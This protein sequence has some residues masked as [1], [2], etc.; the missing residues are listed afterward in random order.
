MHPGNHKLLQL[1]LKQ[2]QDATSADAAADMDTTTSDSQDTSSFQ[3]VGEFVTLSAFTNAKLAHLQ[4]LHATNV[5]PAS[6][7]IES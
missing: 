1:E 2:Q 3:R 6:I 7:C 4:P 5:F